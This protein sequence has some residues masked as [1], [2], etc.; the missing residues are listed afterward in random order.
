MVGKGYI[1]IFYDGLV[2]LDCGYIIEGFLI[3]FEF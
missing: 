1:Y 3:Y 2:F